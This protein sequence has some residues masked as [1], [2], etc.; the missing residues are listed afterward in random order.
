[1]LSVADLTAE[2]GEHAH[3]QATIA[4]DQDRRSHRACPGCKQALTA[5][6]ITLA[7]AGKTLS[8]VVKLDRCETH[9]VWLDKGEL[10]ALWKAV[11]AA[12]AT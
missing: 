3:A 10:P 7:F 12:V 1:M 4:F 6:R 8:P 5:C 11:A 2:A 9:G